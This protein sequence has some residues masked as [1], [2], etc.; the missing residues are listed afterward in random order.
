MA[1]SVDGKITTAQ[2]DRIRLGSIEDH[3]LMQ[4]LRARADAILIGKGNLI[5]ED[6]CLTLT[7]L[8]DITRYRQLTGHDHPINVLVTSLLNFSYENSNFFNHPQTRRMVFT[9]DTDV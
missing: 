5:D 4:E 7:Q 2:R 6:P 3:A 1:S 8:H 9:S